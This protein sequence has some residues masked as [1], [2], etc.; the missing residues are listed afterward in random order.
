MLALADMDFKSTHYKYNESLK[1]KS[2]IEWTD[3]ESK[4]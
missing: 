2:H 3:R 4:I 1:Q